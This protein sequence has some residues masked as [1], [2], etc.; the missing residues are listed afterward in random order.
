[1]VDLK[2]VYG[3]IDKETALYELEEFGKKWDSKYPEISKSW[4]EHWPELSTYFKYPQ[5]VRTLIYTTNSIE[6]FSRQLRKAIKNKSVFPNDDSLLKMLYLAQ[7]DIAKKWA[8]HRKDWGEI[9]SQLE[10]FFAERLPD[11]QINLNK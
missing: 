2:K 6:N 10:I 4:H 5:S 9:H 11:W 8:G 1:M 3:A 7:V